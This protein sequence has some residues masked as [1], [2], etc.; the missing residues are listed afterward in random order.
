MNSQ[1]FYRLQ[2]AHDCDIRITDRELVVN[3][4]GVIALAHPFTTWRPCGRQDYYLMYMIEGELDL[5]LLQQ[6]IRPGQLL[7]FAPGAETKNVKS[8]SQDMAYYW[9]HI[10]G[11]GVA[12]L[13]EACSLEP[14]RVYDAG[15][16]QAVLDDFH[17]LF[18]NFLYRDA[19]LEPAAAALAGQI[20]V[21]LRRSI[22]RR[23]LTK[24]ELSPERIS[25]SLAL[26]HQQ[27]SRSISVRELADLEH[28]SV[29]RYAA[30]FRA[31]MGLSPQAYIIRMRLDMAMELL[32]RTDLS[33]KQIAQT[34]GYADQLYFSRLF[35]SRC[36]VPPSRFP[37]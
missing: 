36:G 14:G 17:H 12:A 7:L 32:Q 10:S 25:R 37:E 30:L 3:C 20:L 27:Y 13:L 28:L 26:I 21:K 11:R 5:P 23:Q 34:V 15:V 33:V 1:S 22:N 35:R 29:S 4:T 9:M 2:D 8:D 19:Y 6:V 16:S 31:C 24:H 18:D